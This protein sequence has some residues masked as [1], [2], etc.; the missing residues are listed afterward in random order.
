[1]MVFIYLVPLIF[2]GA[3]A[4]DS[5]KN[6]SQSQFI[7][8]IVGG[9]PTSIKTYPSIVQVE[10]LLSNNRWKLLCAATVYSD[11]WV[12]SAAHCATPIN[13][14]R[15]RAGST[16]LYAGGYTIDIK[17]VLVHPNYTKTAQDDSDI[18]LF[19]LKESLNWSDSVQPANIANAGF[20]LADNSTVQVAGWGRTKPGGIVSDT[21][22][23]VTLYTVN[24]EECA[25]RFLNQYVVNDNMICA[26][27]L[28]VGGKDSCQG[29]SG[30]P[31]Y[32]DKVL[33]GVVSWGIVCADPFY[34]GVYTKVS[35]FADW[36]KKNA[37]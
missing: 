2:A 6:L 1:M 13:S 9:E 32:S 12:I 10:R 33:V 8:E 24:N 27:I 20:E 28:D 4:S 26:G 22:Q 36:I 29:D 17:S 34:P 16:N 31:L 11:R 35:A 18:A 15:V 21:L 5:A 3:A 30:G 37:V 14:L 19:E 7:T 23:H 25:R